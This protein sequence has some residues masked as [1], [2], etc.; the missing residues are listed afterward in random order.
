MRQQKLS[1]VAAVRTALATASKQ[2]PGSR[3]LGG[4]FMT[5]PQAAALPKGRPLAVRYVS[6]FIEEMKGSGF[7]AR[8]LAKY[9]HGPDDAIVA[10]AAG[11]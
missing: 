10:P 1:A 6:G 8:T 5:I 7:V 11:R 3:V 9:G 2:M 4:H